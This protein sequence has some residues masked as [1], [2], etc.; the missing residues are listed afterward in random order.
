MAV[1]V[2]KQESACLTSGSAR[3]KDVFSERNSRV[4]IPC[5]GFRALIVKVVFLAVGNI[6]CRSDKG[7][8]QAPGPLGGGINMFFD[9]VFIRLFH[10]SND[11][12]IRSVNVL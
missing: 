2:L 7:L 11:I 6:K 9:S 12:I 10:E 4:L 8:R 3:N 1:L 5:R